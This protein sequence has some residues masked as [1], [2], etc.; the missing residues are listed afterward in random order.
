MLRYSASTTQSVST[1]AAT[2]TNAM[3]LVSAASKTIQVYEAIF[4]TNAVVVD[5]QVLVEIS[6]STTSIT[7]GGAIT[8]ALL[9][10]GNP[11]AVTTVSSLP[12]VVTAAAVPYVVIPFNTRATVRWAAVD[13]DARIVVP[14][15]GGTGGNI[16]LFHQQAGTVTGISLAHQISWAE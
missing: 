1:T 10:S 2:R 16:L 3:G 13:P 4:G 12:T 15:G 8:P 6:H 5:A 9:D 7:A 11:S 14:A